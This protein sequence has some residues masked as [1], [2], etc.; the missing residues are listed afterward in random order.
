MGGGG[1][2]SNFRRLNPNTCTQPYSHSV[3]SK[4]TRTSTLAHHTHNEGHY[5]G[6]SKDQGESHYKSQRE[7]QAVLPLAQE[8]KCKA[9]KDRTAAKASVAGVARVVPQSPH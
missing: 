6:H 9:S 1:G 3:I 4:P 2:T 5:K 7:D 8:A